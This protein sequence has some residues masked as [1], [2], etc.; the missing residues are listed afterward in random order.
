MLILLNKLI[1]NLSDYGLWI[2]AVKLLQYLIKP[3]YK[4]HTYIISFIELNN[5][6]YLPLVNDAFTYKFIN[7]NDAEIIKQIENREEWLRNKLRD[8]LI[9]GWICIVAVFNTKVAGFFLGD[10]NEFNIL[11]IH[12]KRS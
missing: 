2:T 4:K 1:R 3:I 10:V 9:K 6:Q 8:K 7:K 5:F 11:T 12:F